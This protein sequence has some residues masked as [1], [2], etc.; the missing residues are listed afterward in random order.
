M[1]THQQSTHEKESAMS[2]KQKTEE[3]KRTKRLA[4]YT[5]VSRGTED[6]KDFWQRI[7]S[8]FLN[9]DGSINVVLNALPVNGKLHIREQKLEEQTS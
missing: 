8:A 3:I 1:N 7:G 5:I 2:T 6:N 9:K 4:V